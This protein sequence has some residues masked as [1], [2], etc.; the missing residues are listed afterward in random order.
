MPNQSKVVLITG[1]AS[2]MGRV[3]A[4]RMAQAGAK[5]A[6]LDLNQEGLR[7]TAD[8]YP[9]IR[10]W[11]IDV[12]DAQAVQKTVNEVEAELGPIDRVYNA[13]GIMPTAHILDQE[14]ETIHRIMAVN[15]GGVVNIAKATM[16]KMVE[17]RRGILINFASIAGWVPYLHFGAYNAS[18]FA[19][20]AFTEVL[21]EET[22]DSDV[23]I[24]CVCPPPVDTP[25][26]DQVKSAPAAPNELP[27]LTPERVIDA[28]E[29]GI[30]S[31]KLWVFPG[32]LTSTMWRIRR[33]LPR[34]N[35]WSLH[36]IEKR[37]PRKKRVSR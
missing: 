30:A 26:F 25:L 6:A 1:A 4:Q 18:K 16:P 22:R 2:G 35:W 34:L 7:A 15:Y 32:P 17:R 21:H 37:G 12:T 20:V 10:T 24:I 13:A 5:V 19:V 28:I 3:A 29:K 27:F 36:R 14:I 11:S 33:F 23:Q 31:K 8:G 9:T